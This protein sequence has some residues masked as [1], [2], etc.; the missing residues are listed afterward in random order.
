MVQ[1]IR[2]PT[3][4]GRLGQAVGTGLSE[5][6]QALAN[7]KLQQIQQRKQQEQLAPILKH[8]GLP[9]GTPLSLAQAILPSIVKSQATRAGE[10]QYQSALGDI[11]KLQQQRAGIS[12]GITPE[13][14]PEITATFGK[15]PETQQPAQFQIQDILKA[16]GIPITSPEALKA[17]GQAPI[18][19]K[20][21]EVA[22]R[23]EVPIKLPSMEEIKALP[24]ATLNQL[25]PEDIDQI[26]AQR[27]LSQKQHQALQKNVFMAQKEARG[28]LKADER[29]QLARQKHIDTTNKPYTDTLDKAVE[30]NKK[31]YDIAREMKDLWEQGITSS[32]G[33]FLPNFL[34]DTNSQTFQTLSDSLAPLIAAQQGVATNLKVKLAQSAKPNLNQNK[35]TQINGIERL[36]KQARKTL[37]RDEIRGILIEENGGEQPPNL[38]SLVEK[39]YRRLKGKGE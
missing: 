11:T 7:M 33:G 5:G 15:E 23:P 30:V 14:T 1:I 24:P 26:A 37:L 17:F 36:I 18:T 9:P 3:F 28:Q 4:G 16:A 20:L 34:L 22:A 38:R 32:L 19:T 29:A 10:Q 31:I 27:G 12:P 6:L 13:I 21:P 39:E 25:T 2:E 35:Q 8:F